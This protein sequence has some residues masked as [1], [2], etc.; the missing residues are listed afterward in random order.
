M[1]RA[2]DE[3]GAVMPGV[4]VTAASPALL[5]GQTIAV[6]DTEG[7]YRFSEL[8][9][10]DYS[11]SYELPGFQRYVREDVHLTAGFTAHDDHRNFL[12]V[13][14]GCEGLQ[15]LITG[16]FGHAQVEQNSSRLGFKSQR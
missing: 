5:G 11:V 16:I 14:E 3:S 13:A 8:P 10:G 2:T 1:S 6:S 15:Q 12:G 7:V 9:I 4:T